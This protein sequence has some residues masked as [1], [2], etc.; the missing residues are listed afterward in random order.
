MASWKPREHM[1][2]ERIV[3]TLPP[4][5]LKA[6]LAEIAKILYNHFS[7]SDFIAPS[8]FSPDNN[9]YL[10]PMGFNNPEVS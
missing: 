7:Q 5:K 6:V 3:V 1:P 10:E 4:E 8:S 9:S 2:L